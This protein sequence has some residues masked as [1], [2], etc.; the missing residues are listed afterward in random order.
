MVGEKNFLGIFFFKFFFVKN[1]HFFLE[2]FFSHE[3]IFLK[4]IL[5]IQ[6]K[7]KKDFRNPDDSNP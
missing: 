7:I 6:K 4:G 3:K 1:F 5:K 2:I